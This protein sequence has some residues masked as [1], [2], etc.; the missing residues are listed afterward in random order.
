MSILRYNY[1]LLLLML[2]IVS[3]VSAATMQFEDLP[4]QNQIRITYGDLEVTFA[5]AAHGFTVNGIRH[6]GFSS[7]F[8]GYPTTGTTAGFWR[9]QFTD[10]VGASGTF[11][12]LWN[13]LSVTRSYSF[14]P[15]DGLTLFF[16][17]LDLPGEADVVDVTVYVKPLPQSG[18]IG[19]KIDVANRSDTYAIWDIMFPKVDLAS[20]DGDAAH[21]TLVV[22]M[23]EG[24][25]YINPVFDG[26]SSGLREPQ[27]QWYPSGGYQ[28]QYC[29]YYLK[30]GHPYYPDQTR[31]A[32]IYLASHDSAPVAPKKFSFTPNTS[33]GVFASSVQLSHS[34]TKTLRSAKFT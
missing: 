31:S 22:P 26:I 15:N 6:L 23:S 25:T 14:D 28:M 11:V 29:A 9:V 1:L 21:S 32:G 34:L 16:T 19:W 24:R 7:Q 5:D 20:I 12:E 33:L 18:M 2:T 8:G 13:I 4:G 27:G 30:T 3:S 10:D 17:G